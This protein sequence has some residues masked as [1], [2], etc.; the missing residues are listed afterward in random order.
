MEAVFGFLEDDGLGA[1]DDF[2]GD[3]D[4]AVGGEAVHDDGG[5]RGGGEEGGVDLIILEDGEAFGFFGFLSHA[6]PS[7]GVDDVGVFDGLFGIAVAG[8]IEGGD[9]GD[10]AGDE[11]GFE[12]VTGGG[13]DTELH[14]EAGAGDHE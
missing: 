4:A 9:F 11:F 5:G 13:G 7:V 8:E 12:F 2:V 6:D 3:F 1:V 10:D 14:A